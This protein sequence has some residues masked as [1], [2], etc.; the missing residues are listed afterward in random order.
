MLNVAF[1]YS[2]C[3]CGQVASMDELV[4][5]FIM[6]V[7]PGAAPKSAASNA[8]SATSNVSADCMNYN[9]KGEAMHAGKTSLISLGFQVGQV[10]EKKVAARN[11]SADKGKSDEEQ[12]RIGYI[13]DDGSVGLHKLNI[14]GEAVTT[15]VTPISYDSMTSEWRVPN[16]P[17]E[18]L[19]NWP[20]NAIEHSEPWNAT[21]IH[22]FATMALHKCASDLEIVDYLIQHKPVRRVRVVNA[23]GAGELTIAPLTTRLTPIADSDGRDGQRPGQQLVM[24]LNIGDSTHRFALGAIVSETCKSEFVCMRKSSDIGA[25]N[26]KMDD[27]TI[28]LSDPIAG[29]STTVTATI[30]VAVNT[31]DLAA[32][33]EVVLKP[34]AKEPLPTPA[35]SVSVKPPP[36]KQQKRA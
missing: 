6:E 18:M 2:L 1:A 15:A 9:D 36:K 35:A 22:A 14:N 26:L 17:I 21:L 4:Q 13:N 29:G 8:S 30:P 11:G 20:E 12:Y 28:E 23:H 7:V 33:D 10:I 31:A 16:F 3:E 27:K 32:G 24:T 5:S 19:A 34:A 25:C